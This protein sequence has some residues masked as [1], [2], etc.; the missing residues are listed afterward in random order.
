MAG[1]SCVLGTGVVVWA[2]YEI[3]SGNCGLRGL[4]L[5]AWASVSSARSL[6]CS[7]VL[8]ANF[9]K[10]RLSFNLNFFHQYVV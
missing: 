9:P 5:F 8:S 7:S 10:V 4:T 2:L 3:G 6:G 1:S